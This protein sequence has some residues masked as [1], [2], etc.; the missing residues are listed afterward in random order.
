MSSLSPIVMTIFHF[1]PA[2]NSKHSKIQN[3]SK[4]WYRLLKFSVHWVCLLSSLCWK[5]QESKSIFGFSTGKKWKTVITVRKR[6][7][8]ANSFGF[9]YQL[10]VLYRLARKRTKS[11][12]NTWDGFFLSNKKTTAFSSCFSTFY[13]NERWIWIIFICL[14]LITQ[15]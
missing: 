14:S 6:G 5:F 13:W 4:N 10:D 3:A 11:D 9:L 2:E 12:R 7:L 8:C 15:N 1:F